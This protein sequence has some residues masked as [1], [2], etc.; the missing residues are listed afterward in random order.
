[1]TELEAILLLSSI[2]QLGPVKGRQLISH[3]SSASE[4]V[5]ASEQEIQSIPGFERVAPHWKNLEHDHAW[6]REIALAEKMQ[7]KIVPFTD[8][9]YPKSLLNI[10][11]PP[12]VLYIKGEILP[13]DQRNIAIVGTRQASIYGNSVAESFGRD[14]A[15]QG[16]TVISGLAR[17]IDTSAHKGALITGRTF[18]V[19]GSGLCNVYP[20]ENKKLAEEIASKGA[21][22][23]EFPLMTPPDRQ[24]FPQ[25]NRIVSGLSQGI[26]LIEA[27]IK[28]GAMITMERAERYGKKLFAIP[29]RIDQENFKG[30][31]AYLKRGAAHFVDSIE[32]I[33]EHFE[34]LFFTKPTKV[35]DGQ[36]HI[37]DNE[38]IAIWQALP[39]EE[40]GIE[41]LSSRVNLPIQHVQRLLMSLILKKMVKEFP[42]KIYKKL[43]GA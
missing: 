24:N 11:D 33:L 21:L 29:G 12:L 27:P 34:G 6:E 42:G 3:F 30:N 5:K 22:I 15:S 35:L 18:A 41:H 31:H 10:P 25:R 28:S 17:G 14:L 7:I 37:L 39:D 38:E 32:D 23:S 43:R 16:F 19:I 4:A 2:P 40:V 36:R 8:P 13:K 26:L 20:S 1:M 9:A